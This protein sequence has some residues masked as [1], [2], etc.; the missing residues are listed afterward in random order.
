MRALVQRVSRAGVHVDARA[1][2]AIGPGLL[3]FLGIG[4]T[5]SEDKARRLADKIAAL[6]IFADAEQ[7]MNLSLTDMGGEI[8]VVSQFTLWG[9]SRKGNR[10]S[11]SRA[12]AGDDARTMYEYF[13]AYLRG[14]NIKTEQGEFG[15]YMQVALV[16]DGPVTLWLE[17]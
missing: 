7:K 17:V 13:V 6:R 15:A 5:A 9:E 10:P 14:K 4:L 1:I 3:V 12:A 11:F 16:N 2:A 8:L